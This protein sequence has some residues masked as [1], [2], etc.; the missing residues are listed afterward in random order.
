MSATNT[1]VRDTI[2]FSSNA[3]AL[4]NFSAGTKDVASNVDASAAA[5]SAA[6]SSLLASQW[7][8][9]LNALVAATD[10]SSKEWAIG[11]VNRGVSGKGSSKDWAVLTGQTVDN[12]SY[13]AK[14]WSVGT[15]IRGIAGA[16]AAKDWASY[17]AGTVDGTN[18]SAKYNSNLAATSA[19]N[20]GT[21]ETNAG[22]SASNAATSASASQAANAGFAWLWSS[23]VTMADPGTGLVRFNNATL[24][25]VTQIA[26][27]ALTNDTSNP[28]IRLV[29]LTWDD[30]AHTPRA[31]LTFKKP[32]TGTY[33]QFGINSTIADNT[34]WVQIPVTYIGSSGSLTN[35]DVLAN[36]VS[37]A[38]NN[39]AGTGDLL[40]ANNLSDL[41]APTTTARTNMGIGTGNS[42]QFTALTIGLAGTRTGGIHVSN[43]TDIGTQIDVTVIDQAADG[44]SRFL[45]R[46]HDA[47][48]NAI[49]RV[50]STRSDN[51]N[52]K[53]ADILDAS[54]NTLFPGRMSAAGGINL[55]STTADLQLNGSA[56]SSGQVLKSAGAGAVPTWGAVSVPAGAT[57]YTANNFG[58]F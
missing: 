20:A 15:F 14:E 46:G 39:G 13:S 17:I 50:T 44:I 10:Y 43:A 54:G 56:G 6:S 25:S 36:G 26:M 53:T 34:T 58:G 57:I 28:N 42:V 3:N 11:V 37:L 33:I 21:S 55:S 1:L 29:Q 5:I 52:I 31:V 49:M 27:S 41:V 8:T 47:S 48:T 2:L 7:A 18:Y 45:G 30:S 40:A 19:I 24:A 9:L 22:T 51:T 12:V 38:G 35:N 32:G 16:G 23:T 4:V